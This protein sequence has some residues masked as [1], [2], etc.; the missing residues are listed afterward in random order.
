AYHPNQTPAYDID[1]H[2]DSFTQQEL[3]NIYQIWSSV[4]EKFSPF[5]VDVTTDPNNLVDA[6]TLRV[7]VGGDGKND[8]STYWTGM[9]A[10]GISY[11]GSYSNSE[12]NK[13]YV[14]PGNLSNG[15][16]KYVA[17]A[18]AHEAGHAFGLDHQRVFDSNGTISMEYNPGGD[19][20]APIM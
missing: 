12:P 9:R 2:P 6:T 5:N 4:S 17:E 19:G 15:F 16:P 1:G 3:D 7:I 14:F 11:T 18:I 20:I 13:S 8:Q 10:G